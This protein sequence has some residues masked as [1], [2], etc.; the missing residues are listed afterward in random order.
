MTTTPSMVSTLLAVRV[1]YGAGF[2]AMTLAACGGSDRNFGG[3]SGSVAGSGG[4]VADKGGQGGTSFSSGGTH[5]ARGGEAG[6]S[7]AAGEPGGDAGLGGESGASGASNPG[8]TTDSL[9]CADNRTPSKCVAGIWIDQDPCPTS[10]PACSNGVCA[11]V[12]LSGGIVTV[13][14]GVL[15]TSNVRLVEHGLE[16]TQTTC[17]TVGS[18]KICV[19]GGIRP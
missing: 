19:T 13:S 10:K 3:N 1:L 15:S 8:C 12:T 7:G 6:D 17:G 11:A 5:S 16:Y 14:D 4:V 2:A 18:Q 9:R